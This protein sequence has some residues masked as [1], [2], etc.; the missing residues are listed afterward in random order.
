MEQH[1][2]DFQHE[3]EK[4]GVPVRYS[5]RLGEDQWEYNAWLI[6]QSSAQEPS[7]ADWRPKMHDV[8]RKTIAQLPESYR[9]SFPDENL[10]AIAEADGKALRQS[11]SKSQLVY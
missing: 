4:Q 11:S 5:H 10:I 2:N 8:G 1:T 3:R 6:D 7:L 9:D